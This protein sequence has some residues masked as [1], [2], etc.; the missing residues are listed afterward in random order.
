METTGLQLEQDVHTQVQLDNLWHFSLSGEI[1]AVQQPI[2]R[3]VK[4]TQ[5][6]G[7][8]IWRRVEYPGMDIR[9]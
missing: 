5:G 9:T 3:V 4:F 7:T 6:T 1:P 8:P 2:H